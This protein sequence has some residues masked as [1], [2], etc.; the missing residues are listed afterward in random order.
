MSGRNTQCNNGITTSVI[1][2]G[3]DNTQMG[4]NIAVTGSALGVGQA[5]V[6]DT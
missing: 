5:I 6:R 4:E 3:E 2:V 1:G